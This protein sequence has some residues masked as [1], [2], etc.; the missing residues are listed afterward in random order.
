VLGDLH[1]QR[2][3]R[4]LARHLREHA[5]VGRAGRLA[6]ELDDDGR[7][8]RLVE[9]HLVQVDVGDRAPDGVLLHVLQ[10]RRMRR[11]RPLDDHVEDRVQPTCTGQRRP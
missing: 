1:R 2:L 11:R 5:A 9:P 4:H 7:L 6:D 10:H 8:D 3:D